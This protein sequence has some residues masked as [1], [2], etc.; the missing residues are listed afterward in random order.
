MTTHELLAEP[1]ASAEIREK[2]EFAMQLEDS[3]GKVILYGAGSLG[4]K[5]AVALRNQGIEP[6]A[7]I[8]ND[9]QL[10]GRTVER[11]LVLSPDTAAEHWRN[12]ALFVV[13]TFLPNCGGVQARLKELDLLGCK[14]TSTF[15]QLGWRFD[16]VLPHFAAD[17][18]SRF[19]SNSGQLI[20]VASLWKD[21]CSRETFR[22]TLLWRTRACFCGG[23]TPAPDQYFPKDILL[24]NPQEIFLDG[25]AFNGDTLRAAPWR[26]SSAIAVEPDPI[27]AAN[28]RAACAHIADV[29]EVL[30]GNRSGL[31]R[32][33]GRGNMASSRSDSGSLEIKV[34]MLD[35]LVKKQVPTFI[36]LD[37]EGDELAALQGASQIL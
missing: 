4:R 6:I 9:V 30:L 12:S 33:D 29:Q 18:P 21:A 8:D 34:T 32:F 23:G 16:G 35:N 20:Q 22:Q 37:V 17:R 7:F 28:L 3:G 31:A 14:F 1:V 26:F 25:G 5:A 36:K 19:L 2:A 15:L 27:N 10:H 24:P 11:I 13:T